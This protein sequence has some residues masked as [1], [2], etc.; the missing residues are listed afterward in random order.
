MAQPHRNN[1]SAQEAFGLGTASAAFFLHTWAVTLAFHKN[2]G[3]NAGS[4]W[5]AA[6]C[7][8]AD[9][10]SGASTA[11][12]EQQVPR[13][14]AGTSPAAGGARGRGGFRGHFVWLQSHRPHRGAIP[15]RAAARTAGE[16]GI[17]NLRGACRLPGEEGA[18]ASPASAYT[19]TRLPLLCRGQLGPCCRPAGYAAS[20]MALAWREPTESCC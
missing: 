2:R 18:F 7:C 15:W 16:G 3:R 1:A 10:A 20:S 13:T 12:P 11:F 9:V 4:T 8:G 17:A 19:R 5:A 6:S 14:R